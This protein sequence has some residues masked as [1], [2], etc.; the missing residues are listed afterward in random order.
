[1][2][3]N[4][5]ICPI[6]EVLTSPFGTMAGI[7]SPNRLARTC[8]SNTATKVMGIIVFVICQW[9]AWASTLITHKH[10]MTRRKEAKGDQ[11][12]KETYAQSLIPFCTYFRLNVYLLQLLSLLFL[13]HGVLLYLLLSNGICRP[14]VCI[15]S[16]NADHP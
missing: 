8:N 9:T 3:W 6:C 7:V 2:K 1:M 13:A 5:I 15:M 10:F 14:T 4:S 16:F 12:Q 11:N